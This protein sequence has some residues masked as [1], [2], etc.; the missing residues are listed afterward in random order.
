MSARSSQPQA[1][2]AHSPPA[3]EDG[4]LRRAYDVLLAATRKVL[5]T[6]AVRAQLIGRGIPPIGGTPAEFIACA[7]R[8]N[9]KWREVFRS[10]NIRASER[11]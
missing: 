8:E 6:P 1:E 9:A 4:P 10:R 5:S 7:A 11:N 3:A 2:P